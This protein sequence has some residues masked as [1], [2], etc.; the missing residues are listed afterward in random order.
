MPFKL[1]NKKGEFISAAD[2][3]KLLDIAEKQEFEYADVKNMGQYHEDANAIS[4]HIDAIL[5]L[6]LVDVKA[7]TNA[8]FSIL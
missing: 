6:D 4:N 5:K 8:H 7:I 2:G 1:L 3:K